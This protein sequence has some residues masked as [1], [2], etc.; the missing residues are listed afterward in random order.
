MLDSQPT[1]GPDEIREALI[2]YTADFAREIGLNLT[3]EDV[4]EL[5]N[6]LSGENRESEPV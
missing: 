4:N 6:W 1:P 2:R 3:T 5:R